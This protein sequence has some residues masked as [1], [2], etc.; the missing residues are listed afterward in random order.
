MTKNAS[1]CCSLEMTLKEME[2]AAR[3]IKRRENNFPKKNYGRTLDRGFSNASQGNRRFF[4]ELIGG[5]SG[6]GDD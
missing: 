2:D 1:E 6:V 3:P 4:I 5:G